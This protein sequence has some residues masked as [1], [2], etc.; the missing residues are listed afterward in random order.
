MANN[1]YDAIVV[2]S[3]ISGGWAA[4]ELTEKG[5]KVLLLERGRNLEHIKDYTNAHKEVWDYPHRN[6]PT[7][8]MKE[9]YPVLKR[10]FP[11]NEAQLG[12]WTD[13]QK[14][15]YIEDKRRDWYGSYQMRGRSLLWARPSYR[16][17]KMDCEANAREGIA[18]GWPIRSDDRPPWY[19]YVAPYAGVTGTRDG[20]DVLPDGNL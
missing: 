4:K 2:G 11:L 7:Q 3:G 9:D 14:S 15:P 10:D 6:V 17:N 5:L 13:E 20:L 12:W 1:H 16:I 8:Q 19:S 18:I